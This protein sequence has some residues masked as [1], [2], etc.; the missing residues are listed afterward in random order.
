MAFSKSE[1]YTL[2]EQLLGDIGN[3]LRHP[4]RQRIVRQLCVDMHLSVREIMRHHPLS[5]PT[6]SQHLG[7]LVEGNYI[8]YAEGHPYIYYSVN[9]EE[10]IK[11]RELIMRYFDEVLEECGSVGGGGV[12]GGG[13]K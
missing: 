7:L 13:G 5:G 10:I 1:E 6:I 3:W 9:R 12:M 11:A 2:T 4:A 8:K